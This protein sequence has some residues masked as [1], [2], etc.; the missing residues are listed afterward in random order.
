MLRASCCCAVRMLLRYR[1]CV[2]AY[3]SHTPMH[4]RVCICVPA[5]PRF[6]CH[7]HTHTYTDDRCAGARRR[8]ISRYA[9]GLGSAARRRRLLR[10]RRFVLLCT[11]ARFA[12]FRRHLQCRIERRRGRVGAAHGPRVRQRLFLE[13]RD[14]RNGVGTPC[15]CRRACGCDGSRACIGGGRRWL[16]RGCHGRVLLG[17]LFVR[18]DQ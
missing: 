10:R 14:W 2:S 12:G 11:F 15:R 1:D 3:Q 18:S 16:F 17:M 8:S 6:R 9:G 7:P 5:I 4:K 13:P